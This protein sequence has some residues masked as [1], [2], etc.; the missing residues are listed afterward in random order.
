MIRTIGRTPAERAT[1]YKILKV[2]ETPDSQERLPV[3]R[4]APLS[5]ERSQSWG[6]RY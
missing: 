2:F 1:T 4:L 5:D 3:E 6:S